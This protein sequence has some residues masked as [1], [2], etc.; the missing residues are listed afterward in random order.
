MTTS[1]VR[2]R[3]TRPFDPRRG[4]PALWC[5]R[6]AR[7]VA[8]AVVPAQCPGCGLRDARWCEEC[9]APWWESPVRSDSAAPRLDVPG[10]PALPL[11]AITSLDGTNH[12]MVAAWKD[13]GR[14]DLD[15]FFAQAAHRAAGD[16]AGAVGTRVV[17]VPVPARRRSTRRR[18]ID[19]PML[20]ARATAAGLRDAGVEARVAA[21]LTI[22]SGEQRGASARDRWRQASSMRARRNTGAYGRALLVDDVVTTGATMAAAARALEVTFLTV[23]A[24]FCLAS[25]PGLGARALGPVS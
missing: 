14:R 16:F 25:A 21:A 18:G 13:A 5:A 10:Q 6:A 20:L 17:V 8:R 19:L 11:W 24:G 4:G 3:W 2:D 12:A 22:G 9:E 1:F 15:G 7:D 23:C